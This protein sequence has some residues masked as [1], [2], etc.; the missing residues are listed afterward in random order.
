M[1]DWQNDLG[2]MLN[3][4]EVGKIAADA[5][6]LQRFLSQT[7]LTAFEQLSQE[8][9]KYGR[10]VQIRSTASSAALTVSNNGEEELNYR[11]QARTFPNGVR[12]FAEVRFRERK[13]LKLITVESM[14]R[15]GPSE[16]TIA[17]VSSDEVIKNFLEHYKRRVGTQ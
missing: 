10:T 1:S 13:G 8:L 4:A 6:E 7:A 3:K 14:V 16:Y 12:P 15:S 2:N 9:Q 5:G 17:D 11:L